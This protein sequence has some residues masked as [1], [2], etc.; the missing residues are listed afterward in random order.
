MSN[1]P[2]TRSEILKIL[3]RHIAERETAYQELL[4][5]Q[6]VSMEKIAE[7]FGISRQAVHQS[8]KKFSSK[9]NSNSKKNSGL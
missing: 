2:I 8:L 1:T 5:D 6:G 3:S 7:K 4:L 9:Y